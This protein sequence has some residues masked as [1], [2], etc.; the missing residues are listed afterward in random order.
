M[1]AVEGEQEGE[2]WRR[3]CCFL[4]GKLGFYTFFSAVCATLFPVL[5]RWSLQ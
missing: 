2:G 3:R 4:H 1:A 5:T